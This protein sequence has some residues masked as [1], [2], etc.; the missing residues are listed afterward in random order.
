MFSWI[1]IP[2]CKCTFN[3]LRIINHICSIYLYIF[4]NLPLTDFQTLY[5]PC[6]IHDKKYIVF[7]LT[8][9]RPCPPKHLQLQGQ[10]HGEAGM[11][12]TPCGPAARHCSRRADNVPFVL[13]HERW[14]SC[15]RAFGT[16]PPRQKDRRGYMPDCPA[17]RIILFTSILLLSPLPT[18][19][20]CS[21]KLL[22][23]VRRKK[24]RRSGLL[25][26]ATIFT[27]YPH[28]STSELADDMF[29]ERIHV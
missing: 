13:C 5:F 17:P 20:Y 2:C 24:A 27:P 11:C 7:P 15:P 22:K 9:K 12:V 28:P 16:L 21:G 8:E 14:H 10:G 25:S 18:L 26:S 19:V 4:L 6:S 3:S 23:A 29:T 1:K